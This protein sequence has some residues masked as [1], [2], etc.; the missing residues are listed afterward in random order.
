MTTTI[1]MHSPAHATVTE[2]PSFLGWVFRGDAT[3]TYYVQRVTLANRDAPEIRVEWI[4]SNNRPADER[5]HDRLE[6]ARQQF[7][8]GL[9]HACAIGRL[10]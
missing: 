8:A 7:I 1:T 3:R 2:D 4:T 5:L 9:S 10:P 6:A